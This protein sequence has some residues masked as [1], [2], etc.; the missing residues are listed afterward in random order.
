MADKNAKLVLLFLSSALTSL[1][2]SSLQPVALPEI[3]AP[4]H[5]TDRGGNYN[6]VFI[7]VNNLNQNHLECYGY[8]RNT[9]PN[10]CNFTDNN[11]KYT[12]AV[13]QSVWTLPSTVSI[14]LSQ[15]PEVHGV[16]SMREKISEN[17]TTMTEV[18]SR[19]GYETA[20][21]VGN[22]ECGGGHLKKRYGYDQGFDT[23]NQKQPWFN[24]SVPR[25][26]NW[27]EERDK[28]DR[29]FL[30]VHGYDPHAP[31]GDA[32]TN[33][34]FTG[35]YSGKLTDYNIAWG[36]DNQEDI[37]DDLRYIN[38][39]HVL[40]RPNGTVE[41]RN[42]DIEYIRSLYDRDVAA[43][44]RSIGKLLDY[45]ED[46][47]EMNDTV[48]VL[49]SNHG[50]MLGGYGRGNLRWT[51]TFPYQ[52]VINVPLAIHVPG[53]E[54]RVV[55]KPV[56]LIDLMPT[57]L[58]ITRIGMENRHTIQGETLKPFNNHTSS[59]FGF[60]SSGAGIN[61]AVQGQNYSMIHT[62][63]RLYQ[64]KSIFYKIDERGD[65]ERIQSEELDNKSRK[66]QQALERQ[67]TRNRQY[68]D[69]STQ[70]N[71]SIQEWIQNRCYG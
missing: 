56:E 31:Y 50:E 24:T 19:S 48:V 57:L 38:G 40:K 41:L 7:T 4:E 20:G 45:L 6:V 43:A 9:A 63:H 22:R 18:F 58:D 27:L 60:T 16:R 64:E 11:I 47:G 66:Y 30:F 13:S 39:S 15:Y 42:E 3:T 49:T 29:Y 61:G 25:A 17:A 52:G 71:S 37:L 44:D 2:I 35:N 69:S 12:N 51:H 62:N 14:F 55:E 68:E 32:T 34:S 21:F 36:A 1:L 54:S 46:E 65:P 8:E 70:L 26:V 59:Q 5:S 53:E 28:D 67:R 10:I 33:R 23:Y